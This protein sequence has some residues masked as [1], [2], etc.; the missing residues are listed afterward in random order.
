MNVP[1]NDAKRVP[2]ALKEVPGNAVDGSG[3]QVVLMLTEQQGG[4]VRCEIGK[5]IETATN[6]AQ[7][8]LNKYHP[9]RSL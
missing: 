8:Y 2:H 9:G 4:S 3:W 6:N 1:E 7:A 5:D